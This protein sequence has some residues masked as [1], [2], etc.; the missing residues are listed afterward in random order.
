MGSGHQ[1]IVPKADTN[2]TDGQGHVPSRAAFDKESGHGDGSQKVPLGDV[3]MNLKMEL[4]KNI[5]VT[6]ITNYIK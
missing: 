2:L 3:E 5:S 1:T 4:L 6:Q